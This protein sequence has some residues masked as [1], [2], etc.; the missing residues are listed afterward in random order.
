MLGY[1]T[2]EK[3]LVKITATVSRNNK[4]FVFYEYTKNA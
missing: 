4:N 1:K 3:I 2:G